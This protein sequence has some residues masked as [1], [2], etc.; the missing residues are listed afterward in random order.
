MSANFLNFAIAKYPTRQ[1]VLKADNIPFINSVETTGEGGEQVYIHRSANATEVSADA[2]VSIQPTTTVPNTLNSAQVQFRPQDGITDRFDHAYLKI[3]VSNNSGATTVITPTPFLLSYWQLFGANGNVLLLQQYATEI[4]LEICAFFDYSDWLITQ[5]LIGSNANYSAAGITIANG[6]STN[7]YIPLITLFTA[8]RLYL[9]GMKDQLLFNFQ[10]APSSINV[11]TG[12]TPTVNTMQL[13]F[14]GAY[15]A[16]SVRQM[17]MQMYRSLNL[18]FPYLG[19]QRSTYQYTL[20]ASTTYNIQ[21]SGF[22][23]IACCLFI[24]VRAVPITS[25]NVATY[26]AAINN[27][28]VQDQNGQSLLG[29]YL[30]DVADTINFRSDQ[31]IM[32]LEYFDNAF[33]LNSFF[34]F[35]SWSRSPK[36]DMLT[37]SSH[38]FCALTGFEVLKIT[39]NSGL[40]GGS[41]QVDV[42]AR[43]YETLRCRAGE[44]SVTR[45]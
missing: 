36:T 24:T 10:F 34:Y 25:S 33:S 23:G 30:R 5:E 43:T 2:L 15:D 14:R 12:T 13:L 26:V 11:I 28:D 44:L 1:H 8:A 21:L 4:W 31:Q 22:A 7:L 6:A 19:V 18:D 9:P 29:Y 20:A 17:K 40:S 32:S 35:V 38:G 39:T 37:G 27:F 41:Y 42:W 45:A 3:N 16:P